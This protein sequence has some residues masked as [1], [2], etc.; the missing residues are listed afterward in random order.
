LHFHYRKLAIECGVIE[1]METVHGTSLWCVTWT[2]YSSYG[3]VFGHV[4]TWAF[5]HNLQRNVTGICRSGQCC[6]H[7]RSVWFTAKA[8]TAVGCPVCT[9]G[10]Y[11][12]LP[13]QALM[14]F[15]ARCNLSI[16]LVIFT[17]LPTPG[18]ANS[19]WITAHSPFAT[20]CAI[21]SE[22]KPQGEQNPAWLHYP[23]MSR[24]NAQVY[25][26]H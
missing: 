22:T 20:I 1:G 21:L 23:F 12:M 24:Q 11:I 14:C 26:Q 2:S 7:S 15:C 6:S 16:E 3:N 25:T 18:V 10:C 17:H 19:W 4:Q 8:D 9:K 13:E 5:C